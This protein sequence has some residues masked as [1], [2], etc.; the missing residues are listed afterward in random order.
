[1]REKPVILDN[2]KVWECPNPDC[3]VTDATNEARPHTRM[4]QCRGLGGLVAPLVIKAMADRGEAVVTPV[5]REDYVGN[6]KGLTYDEEGRPIMAVVTEYADG[7]ND[8]AMYAPTATVDG[9]R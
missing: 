2:T 5:V 9:E 1:M 3:N 7:S 6:E 4:H 8:V